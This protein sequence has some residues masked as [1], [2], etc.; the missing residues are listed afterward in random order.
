MKDKLKNIFLVKETVS[1]CGLPYCGAL[2][3]TGQH[4]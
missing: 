4:P 2:R 1:A 3:T